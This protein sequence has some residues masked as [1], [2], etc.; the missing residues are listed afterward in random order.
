MKSSS[1]DASTTTLLGLPEKLHPPPPL[2]FFLPSL[3][4]R[5]QVM[6]FAQ[7]EKAIKREKPRAGASKCTDWTSSLLMPRLG[8]T[9]PGSWCWMGELRRKRSKYYVFYFGRQHSTAA[10]AETNWSWDLRRAV[11]W[12]IAYRLFPSTAARISASTFFC[13]CWLHAQALFEAL[14]HFFCPPELFFS[15]FIFSSACRAHLLPSVKNTQQ[16]SLHFDL[17]KRRSSSPPPPLSFRL[18]YM[19]TS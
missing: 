5:S 8:Y 14:Y 3:F 15:F 18:S 19:F 10:A 17:N 7:D 2:P 11:N 13:R 9:Q 4:R 16:R 12:M 6:Q 1:S